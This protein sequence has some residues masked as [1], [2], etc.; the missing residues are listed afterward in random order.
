[1]EVSKQFEEPIE[2]KLRRRINGGFIVAVVLTIFIGISSRRSARLAADDAEWVAH[3]Y[4]VMDALEVT[5]KHVIEVETSARTFAMTGDNPSL[6]RYETARDAVAQDEDTLR[7]MTADNHN[8]QRR[9]DVFEVQVRAALQLAESMIAKHRPP[10]AFSGTSEILE[11]DRL[12][13]AVRVTGEDM[14]A[15]GG[16]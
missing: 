14:K 12:M 4:S 16:G 1:V 9:L 11:T 13:N 8:Q 2:A 5:A 15:D 6:T 10:P 7:Q 3:T